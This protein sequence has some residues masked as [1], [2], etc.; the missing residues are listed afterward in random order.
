MASIDALPDIV[1]DSAPAQLPAT[2]LSLTRRRMRSPRN[3]RE[4]AIELR[5]LASTLGDP[6]LRASLISLAEQWNK[7]ADQLEALPQTFTEQALAEHPLGDQA[8]TDKDP[9]T[10]KPDEP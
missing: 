3:Y 6:D 7:L 1:V 9:S 10:R 4:H 2:A 5:R 8:L